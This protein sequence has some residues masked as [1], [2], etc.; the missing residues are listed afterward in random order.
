MKHRASGD[1]LAEES[2]LLSAARADLR[3]DDVTSAAA[4]LEKLEERFPRGALL[5]ERKVLDI[6]V[7]LARGEREAALRSARVFLQR[8]P[9]SPHN[10]KL[11]A[12]LAVR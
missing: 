11:R 10:G 6:D 12:L 8:Y 2:A 1:S 7:L 9:D 3:N 4:T 5:Q